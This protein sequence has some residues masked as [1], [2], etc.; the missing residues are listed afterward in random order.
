MED[1][2]GQAVRMK[3]NQVREGRKRWQALPRSIRESL[4]ACFPPSTK[5]K[6]LQPDKPP[7][8]H[9]IRFLNPGI[10]EII[11]SHVN[12][13]RRQLGIDISSVINFC[14]KLSEC[15]EVADSLLQSAKKLQQGERK[16]LLDARQ[17][18]CDAA[19]VFCYIFPLK[20]DWNTKGFVDDD[21]LFVLPALPCNNSSSKSSVVNNAF[22]N[23]EVVSLVAK[24]LCGA[25]ICDYQLGDLPES[26]AV[27]T[28]VIQ[29]LDPGSCL[30]AYWAAKSGTEAPAAGAIDT[31]R[32]LELVARALERH[33]SSSPAEQQLQQKYL[34]SLRELLDKLQQEK[35]RNDQLGKKMFTKIFENDALAIR[36]EK[37]A[38]SSAAAEVAAASKKDYVSSWRA[39]E[40]N[41]FSPQTAR[42]AADIVQAASCALFD[43]IVKMRVGFTSLRALC[44]GGETAVARST[45]QKLQELGFDAQHLVGGGGGAAVR[46]LKSFPGLRDVV[47]NV[48]GA[49]SHSTIIP[50][51]ELLIP[52][53][54]ARELLLE[55]ILDRKIA[56]H[57][58][59]PQTV[60]QE[61][62]ASEFPVEIAALM[63]DADRDDLKVDA[64]P[65]HLN[66]KQ[67]QFM[68]CQ[69]RYSLAGL[70]QG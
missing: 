43:A 67:Q 40:T 14:P 3:E 23:S 61:L 56:M 54:G 48:F 57:W 12:S 66:L 68:L 28:F 36:N 7:E 34:P 38:A 13:Y 41:P 59:S 27:A 65:L 10:V 51:H 69:L 53:S 29:H 15:L 20:P 18:F 55:A 31:D 32:A 6:R 33:A 46:S 63:I 50:P 17:H 70:Q 5:E 47:E 25:A 22:P 60:S 49:E 21:L 64:P 45:K 62:S 1:L 35:R 39:L 42:L 9:K 58:C 8:R 19:S 24:A 11:R 16:S 2:M 44:S 4:Y 26:A 37:S 30:A 52:A